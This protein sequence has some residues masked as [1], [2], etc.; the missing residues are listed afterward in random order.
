ME[1][2]RAVASFDSATGMLRGLAAFLAGRDVPLLGQAP[3]ALEPVLSGV[4]GALNRLPA[5]V[6]ERLY[7]RTGVTEAVP[8]ARLGELDSEALAEWICD[9]YPRRRY[10]VVFL[11]SSNGALEHLAAALGA[12]WLPQTLLVPV[13]RRGVDRD[14]P[15]AELAFGREPGRALLAANPTWQ[16]HHMH[17]P[18]QDR[19]M[20]A[21]M[22]YFRLKWLRL[23][24]AYH[25]FLRERLAP[26]GVAVSAECG[27]RWPVTRVGDRHVFQFGALG[28]AIRDEYFS[29]G[30]R[31]HDL[32]H[33]YGS[34]RDR[35]DPPPPDD[36]APEAEWGFDPAWP[37][38]LADA[39]DGAGG[40]WRR[41]RYDHPEALS[42][43]VADL[44]RAW[45]RECGIDDRRLLIDSFLLV[46][47]WWTLRTGSVPFWLSFNTRP[48]LRAAHAYLDSADPF[49]EIRLVLF[50]HGT[51]SIGLPPMRDWDRLT[52][53]ARRL[54]EFTGV[55]PRAF[56]RD[57]AVHARAHRDL[58]R[59]RPLHPMPDPVPLE[60]AEDFLRGRS[61]IE[62]SAP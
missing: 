8:P 46:E 51:E 14:D 12:P 18:N 39:V 33:R 38:D 11:G 9:H 35:W 32:L 23:P 7:A 61:D 5:P 59:V 41:L 13:R 22:A 40:T 47:P 2:A 19:L 29:G 49:D 31:V 55:D 25:R 30:P 4:L 37:A 57:L 52:S 58:T 43:A 50:A 54:G 1:P 3:R 24:R 36:E 62:W 45:Y 6:T 27:L 60:R 21:G 53:R 26:G 16:L 28:G 56:P 44:H 42:P 10:P 34:D 15:R 48:S 17:D 20:I